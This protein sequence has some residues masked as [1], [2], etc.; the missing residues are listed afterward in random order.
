MVSNM[1]SNLILLLLLYTLLGFIVACTTMFFAHCMQKGQVFRFYYRWL[2]NIVEKA[3]LR[4]Y[5]IKYVN[6]SE[7]TKH[8][9]KEHWYIR[10]LAYLAKPLGLCQYCNGTWLAIIT[11]ILIFGFNWLI[12]LFIGITFFFIKLLSKFEF[13]ILK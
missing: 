12:I 4:S 7:S 3:S 2:E 8:I 6:S 13:H 5:Y 10:L 11:Y 1:I 9:I